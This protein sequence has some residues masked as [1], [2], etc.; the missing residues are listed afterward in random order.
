MDGFG[1]R[2]PFFLFLIAR[3]YG[4]DYFMFFFDSPNI[5]TIRKKD[6]LI[7]NSRGYLWT[8]LFSFCNILLSSFSPS[9]EEKDEEAKSEENSRLF[10]FF[11]E[12]N[13]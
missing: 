1:Q 10:F 13:G 8:T 3:L 5:E 6:A 4:S 12:V 2:H 9:L 11:E 7:Y